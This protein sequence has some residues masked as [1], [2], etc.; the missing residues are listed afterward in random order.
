[1]AHAQAVDQ[2]G[3]DE[4][5]GAQ[6]AEAAVERQAEHP[7]DPFRGEQFELFPQAGQAWRSAVRGE[8]FPRLGFEDHHAAG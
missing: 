6:L 4:G 7:V 1:M 8:E 3:L 5:L 2:Y